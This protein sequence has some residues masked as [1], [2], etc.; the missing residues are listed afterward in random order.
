VFVALDTNA[1]FSQ[2]VLRSGL[3]AALLF[4]VRR[5]GARIVLPHVTRL[6]TIARLTEE[7]VRAVAD[8]RGS[9][10]TIAALL[11]R[12]PDPDLPA[13]D[14]IRKAIEAR[15]ADLTEFIDELEPSMQDYLRATQ[16]VISKRP[17]N[18]RKE[19]FRDSLILEQLLSNY[20]T[21]AGYFVTSDSDFF[22]ARG[23]R[24]LTASLK[25][26]L[27]A[28]GAQ[29]RILPTIEDV[30]TA[31][32]QEA[33]QPDRVAILTAL[34][35]GVL[36]TLHEHS[37]KHGYEI[38]EPTSSTI[39]AFLTE[40]HDRLLVSFEI[41][42]SALRIP[43]SDGGV[44]PEGTIAAKGS[45]TYDLRTQ[46][47]STIQIERI[48]LRGPTGEVIRQDVTIYAGPVVI[49]ART[50]PFRLRR[51]LGEQSPNSE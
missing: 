20:P 18:E 12:R 2:R 1:W 33:L 3:G 37:T 22:A 38:G 41:S 48:Q 4:A 17:P 42:W 50:T 28:L 29:L 36:L 8:I 16:R 44:L 32:G 47:A 45:A 30:L 15:F 35:G 26:E 24:E 25:E 43:L 19:Q 7:G 31:L 39:D 5:R 23:S 10:V 14:T 34:S 51:P 40:H 13:E 21:T 6:E 11:G 27:S 49:G 9:L 46:D